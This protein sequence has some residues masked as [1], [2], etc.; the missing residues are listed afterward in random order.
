EVIAV[1]EYLNLNF[2]SKVLTAQHCTVN[3][4][5]E[6]DAVYEATGRF[7]AVRFGEASGFFTT[8]NVDSEIPN[9]DEPETAEMID[10]TDNQEVA[11]SKQWHKKGGIVAYTWMWEIDENAF[12]LSEAVGNIE[13]SGVALMDRDFIETMVESGEISPSCRQIIIDIDTVARSLAALGEEGI[14]VL[15]NPLPDGGS[16][17]HW[18]GKSGGE[19]Y[20]RLWKL[21]YARMVD[22]HGLDSLI[23]IWSGGSHQY[24][25]G[26][27][28]V[29]LIGESSFPRDVMSSEA[30][31]LNYT[32]HY[33]SDTRTRKPAMITAS[34]GFPSPDM[35]ARDNA[36]W[37]IWSLYKGDFVIDSQGA[38]LKSSK[39]MLDSFYN[40]EL[41]ICLDSM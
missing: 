11:L 13:N 2:G 27:N 19:V 5:A 18:W 21:M 12:S 8:G 15:F 20:V 23:W 33:N 30:V 24:Y 34:S 32:A 31:K 37:L 35:M 29:D 16:R 39:N 22:Y 40:H 4:N 10:I 38:L 26:D 9:T 7:P 28:R 41:T 36:G 1:Y 14:P 25:P 6:I 17:L 3:T